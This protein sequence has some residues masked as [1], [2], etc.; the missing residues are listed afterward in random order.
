VEKELKIAKS[1]K[2]ENK[3]RNK[4]LTAFYPSNIET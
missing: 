1:K 3:N 2:K 4:S